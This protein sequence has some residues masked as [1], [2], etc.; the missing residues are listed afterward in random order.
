M[1]IKCLN[2]NEV[3]TLKQNMKLYDTEKTI[4]YKM[5][6]FSKDKGGMMPKHIICESIHTN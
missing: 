6:F 1:R 5:T 3:S 2:A 4:I